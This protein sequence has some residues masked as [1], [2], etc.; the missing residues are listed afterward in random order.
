MK[1]YK[2][3]GEINSA[4]GTSSADEGDP[5]PDLDVKL[6]TKPKPK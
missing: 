6:G 1:N 4:S 2:K 3:T 5:I